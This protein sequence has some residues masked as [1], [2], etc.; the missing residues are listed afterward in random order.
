V[1]SNGAVVKPIF[2]AIPLQSMI[3]WVQ[4][5]FILTSILQLSLP[6]IGKPLFLQ[7]GAKSF[8]ICFAPEEQKNH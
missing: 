6:E 2:H 7:P 5:G 4:F 8:G 3:A 1:L